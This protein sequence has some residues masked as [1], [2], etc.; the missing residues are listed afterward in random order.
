MGVGVRGGPRCARDDVALDAV[1]GLRLGGG[2]LVI[3]PD[4]S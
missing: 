3:S 2:V 1:L 4:D